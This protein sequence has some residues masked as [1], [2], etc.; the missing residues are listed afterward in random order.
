MP[1]T[2]EEEVS[3]LFNKTLLPSAQRTIPLAAVLVLV[4]LAVG[5]G[6]R[7]GGSA[8]GSD[9]GEQTYELQL[10][11]VVANET[12][13]GAA[14]LKF[15][16]LVEERSE[17]KIQVGVFPNSELY[18]DEDELQ[19]LQSGAVQMLAPTTSKFTTIAPQLQV[20][21]LPFIFD[22]YEDISE[23]ADPETAVGRSI[24]GNEDLANRDILVL[25]LWVDGFKQIASNSQ[26]KS[27]EDLEGMQFR[28]QPAE[29]LRST[30]EA[31]G[32]QPTQIAFGE[33]YNALQQGVIDGHEN[34]YSVIHGSRA[35]EVQDYIAESNHGANVSVATINQT[36]YDSL[37]EDLQQIVTESAR[38]AAEY[39][40]RIA[41]EDNQR[42]KE[43]ILES[44][45][46]EI[47]TLSDEERQRFKDVVVPSIWDEFSDEVGPEVI[48]ELKERDEQRQ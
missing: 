12:P 9:G 47:Y 15:K 43:R 48:E 30:Y 25:G 46:S 45:S 20:L 3:G 31:W 21:D 36:F 40:L 17:G 18:G 22:E 35:N 5:C 19:A 2:T 37:P 26:V 33:L 42:G 11:H 8:G 13:K 34:P 28:I 10:S 24:Y 16:E 27:P 7:G 14:A 4:L 1:T 38:E 39:N 41:E 44:G 23:V 6:A 32:A 29:A